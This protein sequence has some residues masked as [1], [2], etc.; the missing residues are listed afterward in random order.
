MYTYAYSTCYDVSYYVATKT[1]DDELISTL[2][3]K[4]NGEMQVFTI[5]F[6]AGNNSCK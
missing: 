5:P 1:S 3:F 2:S 6:T 4:Y